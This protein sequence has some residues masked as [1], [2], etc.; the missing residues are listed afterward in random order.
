MAG[1][2]KRVIADAAAMATVSNAAALPLTDAAFGFTAAQLQE[3]DEVRISVETAAVRYRVSGT[4]PTTAIGHPL[5]AGAT[6]SIEGRELI[7]A[8]QVIA[9][10]TS[11]SLYVTLLKWG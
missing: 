6:L 7:K 8:F 11:A 2:S 5:G 3:A 1:M 9:Q 4:A 10:S